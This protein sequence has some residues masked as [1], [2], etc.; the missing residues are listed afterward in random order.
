[1][2]IEKRDK[3]LKIIN[4]SQVPTLEQQLII[5]ELSGQHTK[6]TLLRGTINAIKISQ[7]AS[8]KN[9]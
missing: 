9:A 5:C 1:V 4:A 8:Q 6:A 2:N 3:L 7:R